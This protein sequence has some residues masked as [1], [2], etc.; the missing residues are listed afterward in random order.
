MVWNPQNKLSF[1][2]PEDWDINRVRDLIGA[3][4]KVQGQQSLE[5]GPSPL[6]LEGTY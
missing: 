3:S 6:L 5:I 2:I 4:P 1:S